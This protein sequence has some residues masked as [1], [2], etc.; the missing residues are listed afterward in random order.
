M[1]VTIEYRDPYLHDS[2][3]KYMVPF[4][5]SG[6]AKGFF[7]NRES[8]DY[9]TSDDFNLFSYLNDYPSTGDIYEQGDSLGYIHYYKD[10]SARQDQILL[11]VRASNS[12]WNNQ[13]ITF[14][15]ADRVIEGYFIYNIYVGVYYTTTGTSVAR[16]FT[17]WDLATPATDYTIWGLAFSKPYID[18]RHF[19][20]SDATEATWD[21]TSLN[22]KEVDWDTNTWWIGAGTSDLCRS[23]IYIPL[24]TEAASSDYGNAYTNEAI[25]L[26]LE[27]AQNKVD[28]EYGYRTYDGRDYQLFVVDQLIV[29]HDAITDAGGGGS[30]YIQKIYDKEVDSEVGFNDL[31]NFLHTNSDMYEKVGLT[32]ADVGI[33]LITHN[34]GRSDPEETIMSIESQMVEATTYLKAENLPKVNTVFNYHATDNLF[35][36][37]SRWSTDTSIWGNTL[38]TDY[39]S[40]YRYLYDNRNGNG[41][42]TDYAAYIPVTTGNTGYG[43]YIWFK[44]IV[45]PNY[46]VANVDGSYSF[47]YNTMHV[48]YTMMI[49]NAPSKKLPYIGLYLFITDPSNLSLIKGDNLHAESNYLEADDLVNP[50]YIGN[51]ANNY[52]VDVVEGR[53]EKDMTSFFGDITPESSVVDNA[54]NAT[55]NIGNYLRYGGYSNNGFTLGLRVMWPSNTVLAVKDV[56]IASIEVAF[57]SKIIETSTSSFNQLVLTSSK[58]IGNLSGG[59]NSSNQYA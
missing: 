59:T 29:S 41:T 22:D 28:S 15:D 17:D 23:P 42:L 40:L 26:G 31:K 38:E 51:I 58:E 30:P 35:M 44:N 33:V 14:T 7:I 10:L 43:S 55:Y 48:T 53:I 3:N 2:I 34:I 47:L 6:I 21:S 45:V 4:A 19:W 1:K 8:S 5:S 32:S 49:K 11:Q 9:A 56:S 57:S 13:A 54:G 46:Y 12:D 18:I 36:Q 16:I 27:L 52:Q 39:V 25:A 50:G 37:S 20:N 24:Y